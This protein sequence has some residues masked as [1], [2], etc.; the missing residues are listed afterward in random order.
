MLVLPLLAGLFLQPGLDTAGGSQAV[1]RSVREL[2]SRIREANACLD[3]G[4]FERALE[5]VDGLLAEDPGAPA[6]HLLRGVALDHLGRLDEAEQS[7]RAALKSAPDDPQILAHFGMHWVQRASRLSTT[8]SAADAAWKEAIGHL[9]RSLQTRPNAFTLYHLAQAYFHTERKAKAL[10]TIERCAALAPDNPTMLLRLG[11]YRADARQY[12]PALDVLRRVQALNPDEPGL[13]LN[14]GEV[15]L[16]LP[17]VEG[18]RAALERAAQKRPDDTAVL[19]TLAEACAKARDH[20]AAR[21]HFQRLIDLGRQEPQYFEGLGTA[22]LGLKEDEPAIRALNRAIELNPWQKEAHYQLAR[23]YQATGQIEEYLHELRLFKALKASPFQPLWNRSEIERSL[24]S[25]TEQLVNEGREDDAFKLLMRGNNTPGAEPE[26]LVG[27]LYYWQ[28]RL[29]DAERLLT[30]AAEA[31][32]V[33]PN[34]RAYLGLAYLDQGRLPE[35]ERTIAAELADNPKE[36]LALMA[37]GRLHLKKENWAEAV[38]YLRESRIV[39]TTTQLM[40][41]RAQLELGQREQARETANL[42]T[43]LAAGDLDTLAALRQIVERHA[44]ELPADAKPAAGLS[45]STGGES[46]P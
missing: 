24:W 9:E 4:E 30:R 7:Y 44:L 32:P 37:A 31:R 20:A 36:P 41:C 12:S 10:E 46:P 15:L 6:S 1:P 14:L 23:A 17:D 5:T 25:Q 8:S 21:R 27:V 13:D 29:K 16:S 35:A 3:R 34:V 45:D 26:F 43:K 40:L 18:A 11:Q 2:S 33:A 28:G 22:L 38:R 39:E 42:I 19:A